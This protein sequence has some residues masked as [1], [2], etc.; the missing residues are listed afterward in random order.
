M[1]KKEN[2]QII[3]GVVL[4]K[5]KK[6][7]IFSGIKFKKLEKKQVL[8]K[9]KYS[10]ICRSQLFEINGERGRD[11]YLPHMIGH[12]GTGIVKKIGK[13]VNNLKIGD[14][15]FL[16]WIKT[17]KKDAK[18][19][20][21]QFK[22]TKINAGNITTLS[23]YSVISANRI[24]KLPFSVSFKTGVLL[25]CALPTGAGM[26]LKNVSNNKNNKIL[27]IGLGGVGVSSL[28]TSLYLKLKNI[29]ILEKNNFKINYIKKQIIKKNINY[30][31]DI[32]KIKKSNYNLIIETSG[33][34]KMISNAMSFLNN[35]GKLIFASHPKFNSKINLNPFDL[36]LGKKIYGT[37]GGNIN[38]NKNLK[39]LL[40]IIKTFKNI[41]K[42]F[43]NKTY[44]LNQI[45]SAIKDFET[46]KVIRPLVKF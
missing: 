10:G 15:V 32:K 8:V 31:T 42:F 40:K 17:K 44:R 37:W 28:L 21:Y 5:K 33:N 4:V 13:G 2:S 38:F 16:S 23:D 9:I 20:R 19:P 7:N 25:G 36:I 45:S 14:K 12:E 11:K 22:K 1:K 46:G 6:L 39:D 18:V 26:V 3:K 43:F 24:Y 30:F 41:D 34:A 35:K 27:I 29:D